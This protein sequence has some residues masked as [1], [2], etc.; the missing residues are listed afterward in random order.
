MG[1]HQAPVQ[2]P[3]QAGD[4]VVIVEFEWERGNVEIRGVVTRRLSDTHVRV[5]ADDGLIVAVA[6]A[7]CEL[8]DPDAPERPATDW[9]GDLDYAEGFYDAGSGTGANVPPLGASEAYVAGWRAYWAVRT[10][11]ERAGFELQPLR[12]LA[13]R[14]LQ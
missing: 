14:M 6:E 11:F 13:G 5:R 1:K 12:R 3:L 9:R 7:H 10:A 8:R 4:R 2:R